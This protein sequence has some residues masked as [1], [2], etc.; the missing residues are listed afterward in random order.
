MVDLA[1]SCGR[2]KRS[3]AYSH[4]RRRQYVVSEDRRSLF[5]TN[6]DHGINANDHQSTVLDSHEDHQSTIVNSHDDHQ[7]TVNHNVFKVVAE[8]A[9]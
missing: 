4:G 5:T 2:G 7:S 6:H 3:V 1:R 8:L 9:S